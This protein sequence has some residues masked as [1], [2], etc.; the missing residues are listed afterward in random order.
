MITPQ[1]DGDQ[2]AMLYLSVR[3]YRIDRAYNFHCSAD[4][5]PTRG[6]LSAAKYLFDEWDMG[7][8]ITSENADWL[9]GINLFPLA[10]VSENR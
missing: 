9:I 3:G 5:K 10:N 8:I 7:G 4:H 1:W 2:H 6:E